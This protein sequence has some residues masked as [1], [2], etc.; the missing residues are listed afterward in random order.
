M[1]LDLG[2][3]KMS[4]EGFVPLGNAHGSAIFPL[5]FA[6]E[7]ID[8]IRA[9]HC[10][11]HFPKAEV[12]KV[13]AEW[14]RVLKPGGALRIA[15]PDF[16]VI[17]E[18][19][20]AGVEQPTEGYLM[21]GQTDAADFHRA[22]F[23]EAHLK[24][25]MAQAGLLMIRPWKSEIEDCAA[26]PISLNLEGIKPFQ[27]EFGVS[28]I[29]SKPRLSFTGNSTCVL[30]TIPAL[31][32]RYREVTGAYWG[33]CLE[34]GMEMALKEDNPDAILTMDYDTVNQ[35]RHLATLMQLMMCHPEADAIAPLQAARG[36]NSPL[37]AIDDSDGFTHA[38]LANDLMP[39]TTAHFGLTLLRADKLRKLPKP[40]FH[41]VPAED[42]SWNEG[43]RDADISFWLKWKAAGNTLFIANRVAI[44]HLCEM[45]AWPGKDLRPVYQSYSDWRAGGPPK[46]VWQ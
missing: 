43:H 35:R 12:P 6:G 24:R 32:I 18:N 10:L 7:S 30:E 25:L 29:M 23:D 5:A 19:Y 34:R 17:A 8:A 31:N 9:S 46:D 4:P 40:W 16:K 13:I 45:I 37:L 38:A 11:E 3:G 2:A 15:V 20:V 27:S 36:A 1:K 33:Q 22:L 39:V 44:G 21:G 26:L 41:D 42:G 28:G 14:V